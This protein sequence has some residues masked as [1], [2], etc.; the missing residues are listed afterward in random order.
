MNKI[1][2]RQNERKMLQYQYT[3]RHHYNLAE[4]INKALWLLLF[5]TSLINLF[6][7]LENYFWIRSLLVAVD[8]TVV[9]LTVYCNSS[10]KK[11]S[12]IRA[13]F[14][15]YVL[16]IKS[17]GFN[18]QDTSKLN[19]I[20]YKTV[21]S[22][23]QKAETQMRNTGKDNPPGVKDW[24]EFPENFSDS[25]VVLFCQ[26]QNMWWTKN[27]IKAQSVIY[28]FELLVIVVFTIW[29]LSVSNLT[30]GDKLLWAIALLIKTGERIYTNA[31]FIC[32]C[33]RIDGVFDVLSNSC[34]EQNLIELQTLINKMRALPVYGN[35]LL[36]KKFAKKLSECFEKTAVG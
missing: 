26:R 21:K 5:I 17:C 9:A 8:V 30:I 33:I 32:C 31:K 14:D 6:P 7:V 27:M 18:P 15:E 29:M 12:D 22:H 16:G 10:V 36:Y 28:F 2:S 11:A 34:S 3:A 1:K 20:V 4:G 35:N 13:A 24:Y 25:N 19:E 23:S